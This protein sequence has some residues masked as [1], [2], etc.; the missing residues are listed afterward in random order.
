MGAVPPN[1]RPV[2]DSSCILSRMRSAMFSRSSWE[3]TDAIYIMARPM[4]L[5]V[6][7]LSRM[8]TKSM[9]SKEK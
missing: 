7:K 3:N 1:Q 9:P 4:G 5:D 2:L 6:S 8:D